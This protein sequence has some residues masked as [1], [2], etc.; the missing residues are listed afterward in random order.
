M[1]AV[2]IPDRDVMGN[3]AAESLAGKPGVEMEGRRLDLERGFA[4]FGQIEVHGVI[5]RRADRGLW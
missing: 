5:G 4:Q 2:E 3:E 1:R